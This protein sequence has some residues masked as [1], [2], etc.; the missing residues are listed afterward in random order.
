MVQQL[1]QLALGVMH[2][3]QY[4]ED[5]RD[6]LSQDW[7]HVPVP[8]EKAS[9]LRLAKTGAAVAALLDPTVSADKVLR[10]LLGLPVVP[11]ES[12]RELTVLQSVRR[13]SS[14]P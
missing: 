8:K 2:A 11:W 14:L 3:P 10:A 1:F 5:H 7:A 12:S 6:G 9:A 4:E 13:T